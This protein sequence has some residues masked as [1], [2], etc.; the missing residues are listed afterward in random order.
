MLVRETE[1]RGFFMKMLGQSK[2]IKTTL[3][4]LKL[5]LMKISIIECNF[6][7][8]LDGFFERKGK[9]KTSAYEKHTFICVI[10][11]IKIRQRFNIPKV[12]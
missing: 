12:Y 8:A 11:Q 6:I 1:E 2:L 3:S 10:V 4:L 9:R 7:N 5:L